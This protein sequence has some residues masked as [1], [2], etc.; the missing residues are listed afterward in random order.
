MNNAKLLSGL[1]TGI[2]ANRNKLVQM[3]TKQWSVSSTHML[4]T[5]HLNL[6]PLQERRWKQK[7]IVCARI[8]RGCSIIP[9]SH[10]TPHPHPS[11]WLHHSFPLVT[12]FARTLVHQSSFFISST[13]I[14]NS[15]SEHVICAPSVSLFKNRLK[16]LSIL[17]S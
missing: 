10:F 14:W 15:L 7:A 11:Q 17:V 5:H 16:S 13:L 6:R 9:P 12:P 8:L 3:V 1:S 2:G 4:S